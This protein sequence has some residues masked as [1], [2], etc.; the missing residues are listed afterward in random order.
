MTKHNNL[1]CGDPARPSTPPTKRR[2]PPSNGGR[3]YRQLEYLKERDLVN[4]HIRK[5]ESL[6]AKWLWWWNIQGTI[7][8]NVQNCQRAGEGIVYIVYIA[9]IYTIYILYIYT[10][11]RGLVRVTCHVTQTYGNDEAQQSQMWRSCKALDTPHLEASTSLKWWE[12]ISPI[13]IFERT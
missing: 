11:Y 13:G 10:T 6:N 2:Q 3:I 5:V 12:N 1:K 7:L 4:C 8:E 9:Y